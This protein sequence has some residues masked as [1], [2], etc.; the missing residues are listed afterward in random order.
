M[1]RVQAGFT[2]IELMIVVAIIAILAA[3]AIPA[4]Q[5]YI[6]EANISKVISAYDEAAR[7]AKSELAKINSQ[8]ARGKSI[9][10][11][12]YSSANWNVILGGDTATAP[13][14]GPSYVFAAAANDTSGQVGILLGGDYSAGTGYVFVNRPNHA[15]ELGNS[16]SV[17]ILQNAL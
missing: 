8:L 12:D 4:Y 15:G 3:I 11:S 16:T 2:L 14:G 9:N 1:K 17:T 13:G 6:Q 7:A 5:S 10:N